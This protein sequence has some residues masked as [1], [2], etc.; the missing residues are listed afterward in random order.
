MRRWRALIMVLALVGTAAWGGEA[1]VLHGDPAAEA[2]LAALS[3]ELRCLVCQNQTIADSHSGLAADL[4]EQILAMIAAG[5]SDREIVDFMVQRY[6]DFV[7][8]RPPLKTST[9]L[10]WTG[11]LLLLALALGILYRY[12]RQKPTETKE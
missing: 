1:R 12:F 3:A 5:R 11:P 10:L 7:L 4:R 6:G 8:Y 2:R 9:V